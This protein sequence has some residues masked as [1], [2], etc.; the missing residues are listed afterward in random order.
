MKY[1][2]VIQFPL[3]KASAI[4]FDRFLMIESEL[5]LKLRDKHRLNGHN[6]G[7][8][9]MNILIHTDDL[10]EALEVTK[11]TLSANDLKTTL[12][13]YCPLNTEKYTVIWPDNDKREFTI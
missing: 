4:D 13:A 12:M 6:I 2:L 11:N 1:Q 10:N 5:E 9:K 7:S 3:N 8:E